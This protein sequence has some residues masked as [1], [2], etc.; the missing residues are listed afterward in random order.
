MQ[1]NPWLELKSQLSHQPGVYIFKNSSGRILYVGKAIDLYHR[2]ASY[3]AKTPDSPKTVALVENISTCQTIEVLSELEAL[4][5]EA[6][7]IK[8]YLPP[9]NIKLT[10][11]KEYLYIKITKEPFP[12]IAT[13]RKKDLRDAKD[14]FGPFPSSKTVKDTLKKLRKIFPWCNGMKKESTRPCFYYHLGLCP[15]SCVGKISKEEYNKIIRNFIKFMSGKKAELIEDLKYEMEK[16]AQNLEFEKAAS[17]KKTISGLEYLTQANNVQAYLENPNFLDEQN[18]IALFSLQKDLE[19]KTLPERIECFDIS[20][21]QG[22]N[23]VGSLVVLTNG[24]VDKRWYRRFKIKLEGKPNDIACM[25]EVVKRRVKHSEWPKPDLILVDGGKG[26]VRGA[27]KEISQQGWKVP[28]FGLAKKMEWLYSP[29]KEVLK[30][31]KSSPTLRLLQKI[32][33]EAHRFAL[34]YHKKLRDRQMYNSLYE[35]HIKKL[36]C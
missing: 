8:K 9:Y 32:R 34:A 36:P 20:N 3:F 19:L 21:L 14:Y 31:P 33:D 27:W 22:Q 18:E 4:I 10:D 12:K 5:L 2:V 26:Q 29:N 15:G 7:L 30:L 11:D 16:C 24:E 17:L 13:A 23:Q 28:I 35:V 6:N 1:Q 25:R